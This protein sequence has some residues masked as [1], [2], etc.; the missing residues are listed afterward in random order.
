MLFF[1]FFNS[2]C[3]STRLLGGQA[4]GFL[5]IDYLTFSSSKAGGQEMVTKCKDEKTP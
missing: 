4:S 1:F 3:C 2:K 5:I